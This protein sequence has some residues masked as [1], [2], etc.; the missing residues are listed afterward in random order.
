MLSRSHK[1]AYQN[2]MT[3]LSDF[4]NFL[5]DSEAQTHQSR[6]KQE[7]QQLQQW[8]EQNIVELDSSNLDPKIVPRWQSVQTEIK[9]E[10]KLLTTDILFLASARQNTTRN[11]RLNS[12]GDRLKKLSGYCQIMLNEEKNKP[13]ESEK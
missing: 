6:I 1:R 11:K 7:W 3:L 13:E 12:I 5:F 10:F 2:F 4:K 9:R 8:F